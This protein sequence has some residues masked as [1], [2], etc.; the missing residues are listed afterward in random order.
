MF[1][2][3]YGIA[4][5]LFSLLVVR[6]YRTA[7][8]PFTM[9]VVFYAVQTLL[10]P[11]LTD[12][13]KDAQTTLAFS[14][15]YLVAVSF[16]FLF[17]WSPFYTLLNWGC[18]QLLPHQPHI[19]STTYI[20]LAVQFVVLF[21][22][23]IAASGTTDWLTSPRTAYQNNRAGVGV[24]WALCQST[25]IVGL[26][27]FLVRK[28]RG[29]FATLLACFLCAGV[30]YFLG[31]KGF[32]LGFFVL[33]AFYYHHVVKQI[34]RSMMLLGV[35]LFLA[36]HI[37]LQF[38]YGTAID[39]FGAIAYFDYFQNTVLFL[40]NFDSYFS[41]SYGNTLL[42]TLWQYIPRGL[43]SDKPF[44][45]GQAIIMEA[46][47][48]GAAALGHTPATLPWAA[49]YLDFGVFGIII[50]GLMIGLVSKGAFDLFRSRKDVPSILVFWQIGLMGFSQTFYSAPFPVFWLWLLVQILILRF[51]Q[52]L[53]SSI[54]LRIRHTSQPIIV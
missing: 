19:N 14:F 39:I 2:V 49:M 54:T 53:H 46:F 25:I 24:F 10:S 27:I 34:S 32:M 35:F 5:L 9:F 41:H 26:A 37:S 11:F 40:E 13:L 12:T 36:V 8:N 15:L 7:V 3:I 28:E 23:L 48:P 42:S 51:A 17:R 47:N 31:S 30:A 22:L 43:Y 16:S 21:L 18:N 52:I 50:D 6:R 1:S 29:K 20:V 33:A 4:L 44:A 38:I 45:Y